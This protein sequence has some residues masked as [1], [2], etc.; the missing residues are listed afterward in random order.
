MNFGSD[1][2]APAPVSFESMSIPFPSD[3]Y[4]RQ[5]VACGAAGAE[6]SHELKTVPVD[7]AD[8][9]V[10]EARELLD[11]LEHCGVQAQSVELNTRGRIDVRWIA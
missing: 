1:T 11:R 4:H 5:C 7:V 9:T 2:F 10:T 6:P 8:L 3:P